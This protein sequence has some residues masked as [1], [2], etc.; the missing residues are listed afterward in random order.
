VKIEARL[1]YAGTFFFVPLG[2][3][4]GWL[5]GWREAV[6]LAGLLLTGG[7]AAMIGFYLYATGRRLDERPEDNPVAKISEGAGE[8]GVF[9]PWSW[10]PLAIAAS[11]AVVFLGFALGAWVILIGMVLATGAVIGWVFEYYRGAHAH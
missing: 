2:F 11:A 3:L 5:T 4:Y 7:L 6:G 8:Q 10:W 1:F 9:S